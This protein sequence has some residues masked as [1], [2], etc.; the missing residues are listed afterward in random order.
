MKDILWYIFYG[1][2]LAIVAVLLFFKQG[3]LMRVIVFMFIGLVV[4]VLLV[5]DAA[6]MGG[7]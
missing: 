5:I 7:Y 2:L 3:G 4:T 1:L 6:H